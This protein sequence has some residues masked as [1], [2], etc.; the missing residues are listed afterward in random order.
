MENLTFAFWNFLDFFLN[1][2]DLW[3][4]ESVHTEPTGLPNSN[5]SKKVQER[6]LEKILSSQISEGTNPTHALI[7]AF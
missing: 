1:I 7:S 2:F 3:L 4:V 6:G 5:T